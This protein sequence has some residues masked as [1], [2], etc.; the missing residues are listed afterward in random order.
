MCCTPGQF[1]KVSGTG[2]PNSFV[3][4]FLVAKLA[5]VCSKD[6]KNAAIA[7]KN[8]RAASASMFRDEA[9]APE[10][11]LQAESAAWRSFYI[12]PRQIEPGSDEKRRISVRENHLTSRLE[13][14]GILLVLS[15]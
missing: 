3:P 7:A 5:Q 6:C 12:P 14:H 1:G 13:T 4:I 15:I 2:W 8:I 10:G 11:C 9:W